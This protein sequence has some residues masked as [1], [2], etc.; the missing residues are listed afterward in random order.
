M[1]RR[2]FIALLGGAVRRFWGKADIG[3]LPA[4][5]LRASKFHAPTPSGPF[6]RPCATLAT[7]RWHERQ[8]VRRAR[9]Y[10]CEWRFGLWRCSRRHAAATAECHSNRVPTSARVA[11]SRSCLM[12]LFSSAMHDPQFVPAR[13]FLPICTSVL[14]SPQTIALRTLSS[15]T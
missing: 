7:K 4:S 14:V 3:R 9:A 2:E 1:K 10:R 8:E 6:F 11:A 12:S 5:S 15:L 13:N